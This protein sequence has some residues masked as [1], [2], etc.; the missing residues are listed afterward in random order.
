MG[1]SLFVLYE[2]QSC[3]SLLKW[4]FQVAGVGFQGRLLCC[5][6][7]LNV[8]RGLCQFSFCTSIHAPMA[9]PLLETPSISY[10]I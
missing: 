7:S 4:D 3:S 5:N 8:F 9:F 2:D 6:G 1:C 10:F